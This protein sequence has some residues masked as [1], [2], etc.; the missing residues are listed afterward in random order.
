MSGVSRRD[1]ARDPERDPPIDRDRLASL[2]AEIEAEFP[3]F[4]VVHKPLARSQRALHRLLVAVT[5]GQNRAY[6]DGYHTTIGRKVYVTG[7]WDAMSRDQRY[8]VLRHERIHLR[9]FRRYTL[10]GMAFLYLLIPLPFGL[11]Y[12]RA[13]FEREAY[14]ETI[15][16][17]AELHGADHVRA[18]AFREHILEQFTGPS[19]GWMW[20]F[21]RSLDRWYDRVL[22]GLGPTGV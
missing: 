12:F 20:P 1:A 22:A 3:G 21:R 6:L 15:R 18:E 19:Y 5:L 8:L 9:Q 2:M 16:G 14:A 7:D 11:A 10:V 13:R 4:R 17:A